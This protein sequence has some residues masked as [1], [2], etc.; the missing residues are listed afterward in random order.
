MIQR[1]PEQIAA[2]LADVRAA[3]AAFMRGERVSEV[4][5]DGKRMKMADMK[6]SDFNDAIASLEAEYNGAISA[7]S[8]RPRRRPTRLAWRN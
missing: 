6:L 1:T 2:E 5:R 4:Q 7:A 3:R 8:G